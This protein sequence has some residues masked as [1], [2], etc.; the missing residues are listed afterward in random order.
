[1]K[2]EEIFTYHNLKKASNK[3]VLGVSWKAS[4]QGYRNAL[5][6]NITKTLI[7]LKEPI[8]KSIPFHNFT[9][10][11]R[12]K[13]RDI[14]SLHI[15]DRV[16]QKCLCDSYLIPLLS[17]R[18]IY[19]NGACIKGKGV[20]FT[21]QRFVK[22]L[23][24]HWLTHGNTGYVLLCDFTKYF[25]NIDHD[26][27]LNMLRPLI[28]DDRVYNTLKT[29]IKDFGDKGLG[30]GSEI[31]QILALFYPNTLDRFIKETLQVKYYGRY[32]DDGYLIHHDKEFLNKAKQLIIEKAKELNI[33]INL[34]KTQVVKLG[35]PITWLKTRYILTETGKILKK[36]TKR[37]ITAMRRK[38]KEFKTMLTENTITLEAI[39]TSYMS[40]IGCITKNNNQVYHTVQT[41]NK[42]YKELFG[43][44]PKTIKEWL[45]GSI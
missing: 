22:H 32:M 12:G 41:M 19:D 5:N 23:R 29:L 34:K 17:K 9:I 3:A 4:V 21:R 2:Y 11:E 38:L 8:Y 25:A 7:K 24:A 31:S 28:T 16:M 14:R 39:E 44:Y 37:N 36:P 42:L 13:T 40:W 1:M 33:T 43:Y 35:N 30:L 15:S 45:N 18:L 20:D 10:L 26:I 6:T 27:L